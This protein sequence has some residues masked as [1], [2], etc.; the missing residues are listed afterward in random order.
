MT[1]SFFVVLRSVTSFDYKDTGTRAIKDALKTQ[2][3]A[4]RE[5][6]RPSASGDDLTAAGG[7]SGS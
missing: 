2:C 5:D 7:P 3:R 6:E 1:I 4:R